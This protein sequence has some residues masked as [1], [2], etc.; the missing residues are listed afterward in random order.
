[1]AT[2]AQRRDSVDERQYCRTHDTTLSRGG[3]L[4]PGQGVGAG[5]RTWHRPRHSPS[6]QM[7][8][9]LGGGEA[10]PSLMP[11][12][13]RG[14]GFFAQ[15]VHRRHDLQHDCRGHR[16]V[17]LLVRGTSAANPRSRTRWDPQHGPCGVPNGHSAGL[18]RVRHR[19]WEP[20]RP[21]FCGTLSHSGKGLGQRGH[22]SAGAR[23]DPSDLF[24]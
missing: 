8:G 10:P 19:V 13:Y 3:S 4:R 9:D 17:P 21:A 11:Q 23:R 12:N 6:F 18:G 22:R 24:G 2:L 5:R 1:M 16:G 14:R 7:Y 15:R 20:R